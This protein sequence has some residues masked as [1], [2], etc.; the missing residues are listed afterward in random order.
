MKT[1]QAFYTR[2]TSADQALDQR[3]SAL[4]GFSKTRLAAAASE[5]PWYFW[6]APQSTIAA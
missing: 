2:L 5:G 6:D 1:M 3:L 4:V